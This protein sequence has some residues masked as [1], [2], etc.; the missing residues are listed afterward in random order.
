MTEKSS[1]IA[2]LSTKPSPDRIPDAIDHLDWATIAPQLDCQGY[3]LLPG[4]LSI[5][6]T[7]TLARQAA[8]MGLHQESVT[9]GPERGE[10]F[11]LPEPLPS[12]LDLI[13][14]HFY[15][16]LVRIANRWNEVLETPDRYP[17]DLAAFLDCNRGCGQAHALSHLNRLGQA[18]NLTMHQYVAGKQIFPLQI[19][20]LLSEPG[21]DFDGGELVLTEQRPRMQSRPMVLP[22]RQGDAA[23]IAT[24]QRPFKG[25]K[26]Y[27]RVQTRHGVSRVR[28]GERIGLELFFHNAA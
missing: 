13:R 24:A 3:A 14:T 18:D 25:S 17:T 20:A 10:R 27:Y 28:R 9:G 8:D 4:L 2:G 23:I 1:S 22:L 6:Q 12:P 21:T 26:G 15:T 16:Y 7:D 5:E 19:V 11:I